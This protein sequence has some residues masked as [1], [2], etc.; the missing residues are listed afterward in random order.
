MNK[1]VIQQGMEFKIYLFFC[2]ENQICHRLNNAQRIVLGMLRRIKKQ[3][4]VLLALMCTHSCLITFSN[5]EDFVM[6]DGQKQ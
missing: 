6:T 3:V 5:W 2:I 4:Y 1:N